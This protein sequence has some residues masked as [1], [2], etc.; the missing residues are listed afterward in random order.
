MLQEA[1]RAK[2]F[3]KAKKVISSGGNPFEGMQDYHITDIYDTLV[4]E[5]AFDVID[6]LIENGAIEMDIYEYDSFKKTIFMSLIKN[7]GADEESINYLNDFISRVQSLND[8]LEGK[9]LLS[10]ALENEVELE[11]VKA[12][13]DNGCDVNIIDRSE[14]NL[15]HQIVKK[16]TRAYDK[17]LAYLQ[18]LL[19]QG[20]DLH[21]ANIVG[22]TPLHLAVE[23]HKNEYIKWLLENG[24]DPNI[25]DKKGITPF[26]FAVGEAVDH[27]KYVIMRQF[28]TP[29]FD[30]VNN[31][32]ETLFYEAIRMMS[33][34][35]NNN[36]N[37]IKMLLEDGADLY[38]TSKYYQRQV[39]AADAIA[40]KPAD[41]LKVVLD[42]GQLDID[43]KDDAGNTILHKVCSYDSNYEEHKAK[44]TFR[45][46]K[47]LLAAG[48]DVNAINSKEETPI[49]LA[50]TDGLKTKTVELLLKNK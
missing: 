1:I 4:R 17:N 23:F 2:D 42:S 11:I 12:F 43:Y 22:K 24:A 14:G 19:E 45:K 20:V 38:Q 5:K 32:G 29:E 48:A 21:A 37:L 8:E 6:A 46:V 40:E 49:M 26:F 50:S 7:L 27:D 31:D 33:S 25:I 13:V 15:I 34:I 16:H 30:I 10:L 18:M 47:L 39:T 41:I 28:A 9:S 35:N 36:L 3:E 44:E